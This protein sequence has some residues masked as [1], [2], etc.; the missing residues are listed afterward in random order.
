MAYPFYQFQLGLLTVI[1]IVLITLERYLKSKKTLP[2]HSKDI[3]IE[4]ENI[5]GGHP[6]LESDGAAVSTSS[7][8]R[9][10]ALNTLMRKYLL[11]YAIV[12]GLYRFGLVTF[13]EVLISL[14]G[15]DWLQ[16]PYVYS[17]Y[18]EQYEY[19][20]RLVAVLFVTGFLSAAVFAPLVGVW[21]DT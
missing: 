18:R 14:K 1:C 20:E 12:M 3:V 4:E 13:S 17:L 10:G 19:P 2:D 21:A 5:E 6:L 15:A 16:G 8:S 9:A 7:S 11:V